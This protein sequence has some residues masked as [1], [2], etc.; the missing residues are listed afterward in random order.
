[1]A[2][3]LPKKTREKVN[4]IQFQRNR[5]LKKSKKQETFEVSSNSAPKKKINKK[6][7]GTICAKCGIQW[8]NE[9]EKKL[10][11]HWVQCSK[12]VQILGPHQ[13]L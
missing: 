10:D 11:L 2:K 1:M 3:H 4:L 13:V 5:S 7:N 9:E 6:K 8:D 12:A